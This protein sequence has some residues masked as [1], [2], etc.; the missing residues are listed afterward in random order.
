MNIVLIISL[1]IIALIIINA[2][3]ESK[4]QNRERKELLDNLDRY[5]SNDNKNK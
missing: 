5:T 3:I 1:S 4:V 2:Y